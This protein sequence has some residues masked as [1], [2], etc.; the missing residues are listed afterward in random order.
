LHLR[1]ALSS[2]L[3]GEKPRRVPLNRAGSA[4]SVVCRVKNGAHG[5]AFGFVNGAGG[6]Y[7]SAFAGTF[8]PA[9]GGRNFHAPDLNPRLIK[10]C[11]DD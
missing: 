9:S 8:G 10:S 3:K 2:A 6:E 5:T 7:G 4:P 11:R 1:G